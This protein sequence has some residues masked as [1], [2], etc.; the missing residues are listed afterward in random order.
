MPE[1]DTT[2]D[3][4]GGLALFAD[5][6]RPELEEVAHTFEEEYFADGQRVLRRGFA[7]AGFYVIVDGEAIVSAD[8]AELARLARGDFFGETSLLLGETPAADVTAAGR[9]RCLVLAGPML[10]GFLRAHPPV[11]FRMLQAVARRLRTA[12]LWR[13]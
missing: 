2:I 1:V 5:L 9:V 13:S 8:G 12:T 10:E 3:L 6:S 11:M 7:G 4:L